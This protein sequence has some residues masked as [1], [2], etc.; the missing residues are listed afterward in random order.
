MIGLRL[1]DPDGGPAG[2]SDQAVVGQV[3]EGVLK[4]LAGDHLEERDRLKKVVSIIPP[5]GWKRRTRGGT[6]TGSDLKVKLAIIGQKP[7]LAWA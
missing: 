3:L 4:H 1:V 2:E 6:S 5:L 7:G